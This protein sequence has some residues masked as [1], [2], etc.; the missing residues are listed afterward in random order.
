VLAWEIGYRYLQGIANM[1]GTEEE[2]LL[3]W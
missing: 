3:F 2:G 1:A